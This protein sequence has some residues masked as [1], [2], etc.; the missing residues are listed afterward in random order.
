MRLGLIRSQHGKL[1]SKM[2]SFLSP[3][4]QTRSCDPGDCH[5]L[6]NGFCFSSVELF[7]MFAKDSEIVFYTLCQSDFSLQ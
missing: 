1:A 7:A 2:E 6:M 3:Q 4:I 5:N